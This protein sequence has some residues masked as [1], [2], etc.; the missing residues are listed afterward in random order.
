M[1]RTAPKAWR[2]CVIEL[3]EHDEPNAPVCV[4]C[5]VEEKRGPVVNMNPCEAAIQS[6]KLIKLV[7]CPPPH[8]AKRHKTHRAHDRLRG[9]CNQ[10]AQG[11]CLP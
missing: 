8:N 2:Y 5:P 3:H 11:S 7:C 6:G 1:L 10:R 9:N 4:V